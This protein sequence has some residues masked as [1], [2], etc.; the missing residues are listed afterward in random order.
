MRILQ[1]IT[2]S[3]IAGAE[4]STASLC[5]H[6]QQA[7]H[8]VTVACKAGHPFVELMRSLQVDVRP[9]AISGKANVAAGA[10]LAALAREVGAQVI[11][12]QLSTAALWGTVAAHLAGIPA[13]AHVR[14]LNSKTC[15][16]MA[17]RVVAIS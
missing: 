16:L 9:L 5:E 10:R 3:K 8:Q 6:L 17:D 2:P 13:V 15:Y 11:A 12:T 1:V 7:G 14:A 4:R